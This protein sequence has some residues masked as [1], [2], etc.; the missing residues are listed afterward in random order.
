MNI[1]CPQ[2]STVYRLPD[3]KA[4]AG[5]KLRCSVCRHVFVLAEEEPAEAPL[6]LD[7][8]EKSE[9]ALG[10]A[11]DGVDSSVSRPVLDEGLSF[12]ETKAE[13]DTELDIAVD[14]SGIADD[15]D[16]EEGQEDE[17]APVVADALDMPEEKKSRFEGMFGLLLC[18]AIIAGGVWAWQNTNY[19]DGLKSLFGEQELKV[20]KAAVEPD[21]VISELKIVEHRGYP[22][23][24][25]KIG[26][27]LV[28][29]GKVRNNF[30]TPRE[31]ISLEAELFGA[32]GKVLATRR[33]LAGVCLSPFQL[34]VLDKNELENTLNR[35]LDIISSNINV[36]P[37][38]EVPFTVVFVDAPA[39]ASDYKVRIVEASMPK[40][41]G[42]LAE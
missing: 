9:A 7:E 2:C 15:E 30:S 33:Q 42:N 23:K 14:A 41:V 25:K 37:G 29:E 20:E 36:L 6:S 4:K 39:D 27:L 18:I 24:N 13:R 10:L 34:E 31:L 8:E 11:M 40:P 32:D 28:I 5:A 17:D 38:A 35:K 12:G 21:D 19:L 1:T 16:S 3:E 22:L 26:S